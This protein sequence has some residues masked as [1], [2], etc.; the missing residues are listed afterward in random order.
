MNEDNQKTENEK[1]EEEIELCPDCR[2]EL[3]QCDCCPDCDTYPCE[4]PPPDPQYY[5]VFDS[6]GDVAGFYVDEIHGDNIPETAIPISTEDWQ[7]YSA[8]ASKYKLDDGVIRRKTEEEIEAE[9][10]ARPPAP[11]TPL[12]KLE[13]A[14]LDNKEAI[15]SLY[16]M[17]LG[18]A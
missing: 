9:E 7:T 15:A 1:A 5:I 6:N 2:Y 14:D 10:E 11:K 12:Q 4:C 17:L 16:E 8:D 13:E 3:D 18:G